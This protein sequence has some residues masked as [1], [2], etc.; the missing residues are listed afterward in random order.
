MDNGRLPS[1]YPNIPPTDG[2]PL[3]FPN[4]VPE[5]IIGKA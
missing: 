5:L 3:R 2:Q 1:F 4:G